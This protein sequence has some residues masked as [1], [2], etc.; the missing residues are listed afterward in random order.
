MPIQIFKVLP[1]YDISPR[2]VISLSTKS[3][4]VENLGVQVVLF[5]LSDYGLKKKGFTEKM[6][7]LGGGNV[8][9]ICSQ[10]SM[11]HRLS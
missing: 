2:C 3:K 8:V 6:L 7:V 11:C 9:R 1:I 10:L 5:D 4:S